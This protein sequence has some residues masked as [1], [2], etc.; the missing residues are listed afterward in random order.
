LTGVDVDINIIDLSGIMDCEP[1]D[2]G[3]GS[4]MANN[5]DSDSEV[6]IVDT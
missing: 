1:G 2:E 3:E 4:K 5:G 6:E